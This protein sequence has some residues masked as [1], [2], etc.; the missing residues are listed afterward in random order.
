MSGLPETIGI[1]AIAIVGAMTLLWLLSVL[2]RDASIVDIAWG[3][4]YV[5]VAVVAFLWGEGWHG[6]KVLV[7]AL[8]ALWGLRLGWHIYGRNRGTGE[9]P[10]Y[11]KWRQDAGDGWWWYSLAYANNW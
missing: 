1:T 2:I 5:A 11:V 8:V 4:L 10:R 6:R 3:P 9:D 7:L